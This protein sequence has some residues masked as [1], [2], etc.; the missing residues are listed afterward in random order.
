M[1]KITTLFLLVMPGL[2]L[3]IKQAVEIDTYCLLGKIVD[4]SIILKGPRLD[5]FAPRIKK[6][7]NDE[8]D[9]EE[10]EERCSRLSD[11]LGELE[12]LEKAIKSQSLFDQNNDAQVLDALE[13]KQERVVRLLTGVSSETEEKLSVEERNLNS[14]ETKLFKLLRQSQLPVRIGEGKYTEISHQLAIL[15]FFASQTDLSTKLVSLIGIFKAAL[16][17]WTPQVREDVARIGW[18]WFSLSKRHPLVSFPPGYLLARF[19]EGA[20]LANFGVTSKEVSDTGSPEA[21]TSINKLIED[22]STHFKADSWFSKLK[23]KPD[24]IKGLARADS[25]GKSLTHRLEG[26]MNIGVVEAAV[27]LP[28]ELF[29]AY[30]SRPDIHRI[31]LAIKGAKR[32]ATLAISRVAELNSGG[33]ETEL[34]KAIKSSPDMVYK[35]LNAGRNDN[36]NEATAMLAQLKKLSS[37]WR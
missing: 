33:S 10:Y 3:S 35:F 30:I 1:R 11:G 28:G 26:N 31:D 21:Q 13:R 24:L 4:A 15:D 5:K 9:S 23:A 32:A 20:S 8:K 36:V 7:L 34:M 17:R 14:V 19:C 16:T 6:W 25:Y 2:V 18:R 29:V 27:R 22:L 37:R 12:K